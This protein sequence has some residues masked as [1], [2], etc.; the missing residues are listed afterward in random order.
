M[1]LSELSL[2]VEKKKYYKDIDIIR[3]VRFVAPAHNATVSPPIG[4][5][6]GQFGINIMD[7]CKKFNESSKIYDENVLLIVFLSLFRNRNFSFLIKGPLVSFLVNEDH[8]D[9]DLEI[10]PK[11]LLFTSF[12]KIVRFKSFD[13]FLTE[14]SISCSVFGTLRSMHLVLCN[15]IF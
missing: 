5:I 1:G 2:I 12:F 8:C 7:F 4:P 11:Y 3:K 14:Y 15:D 6:L 13:Y 9:L 10:V